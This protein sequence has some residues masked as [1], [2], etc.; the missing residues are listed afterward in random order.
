MGIVNDTLTKLQEENKQLTKERDEARQA[1]VT[2]IIGLNHET[3]F[4]CV[5]GH[6][7]PTRLCPNDKCPLCAAE[8]EIAILRQDHSAIAVGVK[9]A[10][11]IQHWPAH[12]EEDETF[13][14]LVT[15]LVQD[16]IGQATTRSDRV[17][18]LQ[19]ELMRQYHFRICRCDVPELLNADGD[20]L[21]CSAAKVL[22]LPKDKQCPTPTKPS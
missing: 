18:D 9:K 1:L 4:A 20:C 6:D 2:K 10:L 22:G 14:Q 19:Q 16:R 15:R 5:G 21:R 8:D 3:R 13:Q 7:L 17:A 11:G 12:N